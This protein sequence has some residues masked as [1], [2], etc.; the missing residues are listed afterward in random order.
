MLRHNL[1]IFWIVNET[2]NLAILPLLNSGDI[3][4]SPDE[5]GQLFKTIIGRNIL[6][7]D[8]GL[9]SA[10]ILGL[11]NRNG[12]L[13]NVLFGSPSSSAIVINDLILASLAAIFVLLPE[14]QRHMDEGINGLILRIKIL[15]RVWFAHKVKSDLWNLI[16]IDFNGTKILWLFIQSPTSKLLKFSFRGVHCNYIGASNSNIQFAGGT[17]STHLTS[18]DCHYSMGLSGS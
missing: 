12:F 11:I 3:Q 17:L 14:E 5:L 9:H 7:A 15:L 1:S 13:L 6:L 18:T 16:T 8:V 2:N 4:I 10:T